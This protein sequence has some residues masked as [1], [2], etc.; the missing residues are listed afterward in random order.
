MAVLIYSIDFRYELL[1][2][3]KRPGVK[4]HERAKRLIT[5]LSS[6]RGKSH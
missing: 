5:L 3:L 2:H 6:R 4:N 1:H